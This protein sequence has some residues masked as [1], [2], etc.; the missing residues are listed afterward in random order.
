M[1]PIL[2]GLSQVAGGLTHMA[3]RVPWA[4]GLSG[5]LVTEPGSGYWPRQAREPVRF[6]AAAAALAAQEISVFIEIGQ[7]GTLSAL[8]P[9]A[10]PGGDE[11]ADFIPVLRPGQAACAA[12]LAALARAHVRGAEVDWA[13]VLPA[14]KRPTC[15]PTRPAAA[16][17]AAAQPRAG[18]GHH[19]RDGSQAALFPSTGFRSRRRIRWSLQ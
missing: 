3:P 13:A 7:D 4:C 11:V 9:A 6:A 10:L 2:D 15:P 14:G 5:N 19:V 17:L 12:V 18:R 16:L 8:G 1:D